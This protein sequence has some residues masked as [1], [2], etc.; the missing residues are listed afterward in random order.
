MLTSII[1]GWGHI[2]SSICPASVTFGTSILLLRCLYWNSFRRW[3]DH[4]SSKIT[5]QD[6]VQRA[7]VDRKS[8]RKEVNASPQ[9][10]R[11]TR[12]LKNSEM[13]IVRQRETVEETAQ[14]G[15]TFAVSL[16]HI[17]RADSGFHLT[18]Q[19]STPDE[20]LRQSNFCLLSVRRTQH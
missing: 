5:R 18:D 13:G 17:K 4:L 15:Q 9:N 11:R 8:W 20:K 7:A 10:H 1:G 14:P 12:C 19:L 2:S 16:K 6:T 3:Q